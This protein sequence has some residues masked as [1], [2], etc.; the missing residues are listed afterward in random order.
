MKRKLVIMHF[1]TF[2][3]NPYIFDDNTGMV[4]PA[5]KTMLALLQEHCSQPL[6]AAVAEL[7]NQCPEDELVQEASFIHRWE[8]VYGGEPLMAGKT[9]RALLEYTCQKAP[10]ELVF[11]LTTNGLL[12]KGSI[13]DTLVTHN[14]AINVSLD[15]DRLDH[16]RNRVLPK[17]KGSFDL[18]MQ[19]LKDFR[20]RYPHYDKLSLVGVYDW[21]TNLSQVTEFFEANRSWLPP[22]QMLNRVNEQDTTYY[23]QFSGEDIAAFRDSHRRLEKIYLSHKLNREEVPVY[24]RAYFEMRLISALLRRR[25]G[26][27][28]SPLL[29]FTN[30]CIPGAKL[31]VRT[32]GT[33]D[34]CERVNGTMPV[35]HVDTG[36]NYEEVSR[37]I[38]EYNRRICLGCWHCPATKLCNNCFA[39][40]N[41]NG[42]F[43]RPKGE[44]DCNSIRNYSRQALQVVYSLLEEEPNA[45]E[46]MSYFN[47]ELRLLES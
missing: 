28:V 32:D 30:T 43:V 40:C 46:D 38:R 10:C 25:G 29:P 12:L 7:A 17:G 21:K 27:F 42:D 15:G 37:I 22:L 18:I 8:T 24:P 9:L 23:N 16:N 5:S 13:V 36:I 45:F 1:Y 2:Q 44:G 11:S 47:P 6:E 41:T 4:F 34:I 3:G 31:T 14:V 19:N 39:L 20:Q 35:G 33:F 26:N